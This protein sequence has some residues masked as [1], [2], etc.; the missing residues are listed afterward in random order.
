M[1]EYFIV[2]NGDGIQGGFC[3]WE[4]GAT[5]IINAIENAGMEDVFLVGVDGNSSGFDQ[6]RAGTQSVTIMQNFENFT[7]TSLQ[8]AKDMLEGKEV[9]A[10]NFLDL[11]IVTLDNID[12]FTPP[13]W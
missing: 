2:K 11:D 6:V 9:Q 3:H 10:V 4:G 7:M 1:L 13:E 12:D 8:L 5:G